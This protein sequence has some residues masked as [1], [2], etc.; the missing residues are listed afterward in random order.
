MQCDSSSMST[1]DNAFTR[2]GLETKLVLS[3]DELRHA[4]QTAS[5][6]A[7]PDAGGCNDHFD[8]I[9]QAYSTLASPS[10]RLIHWLGLNGANFD[11]RGPLD[12]PL[13]DLF[14]LVG[15]I[16]QT[17]E[18]V[19]K[20]RETARSSLTRA[21]L[22]GEIQTCREQ[23]DHVISAVANAITLECADFSNLQNAIPFPVET[24]SRRSRNLA[25]LEKWQHSLKSLYARLV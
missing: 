9:Q 22:E 3:E 23:L 16:C 4:W 18:A 21:L 10:K 7:H 8:L 20:R 5:A 2:L 24:A 1:D 19:I 14:Q 11:P 13:M 15:E 6:T 25:F 12:A 17:T